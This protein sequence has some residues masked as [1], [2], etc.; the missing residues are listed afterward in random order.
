MVCSMTSQET[1]DWLRFRGTITAEEHAV[2]GNGFNTLEANLREQYKWHRL[3][4]RLDRFPFLAALAELWK[5]R[6]SVKVLEA[7]A[8]KKENDE[9]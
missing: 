2:D 5:L 7:P 6:Q 8:Y 9:R 1:L 3:Q 4:G